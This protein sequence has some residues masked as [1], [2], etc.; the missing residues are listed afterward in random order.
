MDDAHADL[1]SVQRNVILGLLLALAAG[2]WVLLVWQSADMDMTMASSAMGMQAPLFLA[3]WVVMMVAM[4]F[5]T[6]APMILT[7]HEVKAGR[8]KGGDAFVST[9]VFVLA[10]ILVWTL[11]GTAA[12]LGA[13]AAEALAKRAELSSVATARIGGVIL[14]AA[15]IYQ[16]TPLKDLC[17]SK[18]R[19]PNNFIM[20]SWRDGAAGALR[21]G[22]L[23]GAYCLG[24]CWLLFVILFPL[25]IMNIGAMLAV[26]LIILAEKTLPWPRLAPYAA[27]LGL[28]LYG[29]LVIVSPQ[30]LL[31]F[32]EEGELG[33]WEHRG[34]I[35]LIVATVL[36]QA[37]LL[38]VL[39]HERQR[40][41]HAEV[42][43]TTIA[44]ELNQPLTTILANSQAAEMLLLS[45]APNLLE[46]REILS[47]IQ[48][49]DQRAVEVIRHFRSLSKKAAFER[50][51]NDLNEI[52]R[53]TIG[54]L[55]DMA[56][57]READL[58]I[59]FASG[60]LRIKGDRV[61]LQQVII[62]LIVNA[63]DA[64]SVVPRAK[65]KVTIATARVENF[66]EVAVSDT[67]PGIP[68]GNA[69]VVFQPFFTTKPQG[70][71]IGLYIAR[72]IT[73]AH[74]GRIWTKNQI[75]GGAVFHIRLP[76]S[77]NCPMHI[78]SPRGT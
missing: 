38:I 57:S 17:L 56:R 53:E 49:D 33:A 20:M 24:C 43:V 18:C 27:A 77:N 60:E 30:L 61:Q 64:V 22:L 74:G 47:D 75:G 12:Y 65:R 10:Y 6:A 42:L 37:A 35:L 4:M 5:P 78:D 63:I 39:L 21:M 2:A 59:E 36:T 67:G 26:T 76:C 45:S 44:H 71:G 9:C 8:H 13:V 29:A 31:T 62:N 16:L 54:F 51:D 23:H 50:R 1:L 25:G 48:R 32:Q 66:A 34:P 58:G 46:V 11:A 69:D 15:G 3:I 72:T 40:R 19:T 52:V 41:R 68:I 55:S 73:E 7:F 28:L 70:M 14:V